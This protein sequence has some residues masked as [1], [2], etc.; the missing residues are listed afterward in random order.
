MPSLSLEKLVT[1]IRSYNF[2]FSRCIHMYNLAWSQRL[3]AH[4]F[5]SVCFHLLHIVDCFEAM[6]PFTATSVALRLPEAVNGSEWHFRSNSWTWSRSDVLPAR[7]RC[8]WTS[9]LHQGNSSLDAEGWSICTVRWNTCA[10]TEADLGVYTLQF[11]WHSYPRLS[12]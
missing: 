8:R 3:Y 5:K 12:K 11:V 7:C 1:C 9:P 2:V 4:V 6:S 10:K